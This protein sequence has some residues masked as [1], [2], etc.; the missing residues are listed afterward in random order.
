MKEAAFKTEEKIE[1]LKQTQAK[2]QRVLV[3]KLTIKP[4]HTL[5]AYNTETG[6]IAPAKFKKE[7]EISWDN[8]VKG[9]V[10]GKRE[11]TGES[12]TVYLG[13][14]NSKNALR[15]LGITK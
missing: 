5:F 14:L 11:I 13:A 2:S 6:E 9:A 10:I 8:A 12:N 1:V 7:P 4:N 3:G 15:K